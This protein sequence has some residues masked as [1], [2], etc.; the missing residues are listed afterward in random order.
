MWCRHAA[1]RRQISKEGTR[2]VWV[3][4]GEKVRGVIGGAGAER[5][6]DPGGWDDSDESILRR[7][8]NVLLVDQGVEV[9]RPGPRFGV[10]PCLR[11]CLISL[12]TQ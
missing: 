12:L 9:A 6:E 3:R 10:T 7:A 1:P 4:S 2:G 11:K 5:E 8:L